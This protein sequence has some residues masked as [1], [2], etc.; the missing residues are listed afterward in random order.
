MKRTLF[1]LALGLGAYASLHGDASAAERN[2]H[3]VVPPGGHVCFAL[4]AIQLPIHVMISESALNGGTQVPSE[5]IEAIVNQDGKST[6]MTWLGTNS[7]GSQLGSNSIATPL[8]ASVWGGAPP[9]FNA[10][11]RVC[12]LPNREIG[13]F[14]NAQTTGLPGH[15]YVTMLY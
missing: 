3:F 1:A 4:P 11:L 10:Q 14:Q 15:Y 2:L 9:T 6:Q 7:D 5:L 13:I 12:S 8:I